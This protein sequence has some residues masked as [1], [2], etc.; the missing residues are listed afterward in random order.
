MM[1]TLKYYYCSWN[2]YLL[3]KYF[4]VVLISCICEYVILGTFF[5]YNFVNNK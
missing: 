4:E 3:I 2:L 1:C 5:F